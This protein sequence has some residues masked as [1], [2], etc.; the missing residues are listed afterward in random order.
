VRYAF[1][2]QFDGTDCA[3]ACL[4][5]VCLHYKKETVITKLRDIMGTDLKGTNLIGLSNA[6]DELGFDSRAIRV[7][8]T[9]LNF[10]PK[11]LQQNHIKVENF[12]TTYLWFY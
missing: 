8:K 6:A 2:K 1:V 3:A 7:E 5:M 4:A 12:V 9:G 10:K 11:F